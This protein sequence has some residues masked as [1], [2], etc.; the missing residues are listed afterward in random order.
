MEPFTITEA[1]VH[2][3]HKFST[4]VMS[5]TTRDKLRHIVSRIENLEDEK[6]NVS[7]CI[8]E[9]YAESKAFG[10]DTKALRALIKARKIERAEREE[11]QIMLDLYM[12]VTGDA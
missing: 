10:F 9:V 5:E 6:A 12:E 3:A 2:A 7:E 11:Q 8:K 4:T 1:D